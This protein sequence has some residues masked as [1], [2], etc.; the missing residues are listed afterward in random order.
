[1]RFAC[2]SK[3]LTASSGDDF[4]CA[5]VANICGI[6]KVLKISSMTAFVLPG[7]PGFVVYFSAIVVRIVYLP[8]GLCVSCAAIL[9]M[10]GHPPLIA[11]VHGGNVCHLLRMKLMA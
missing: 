5:T 8:F 3:F 2:R 11:P 1:M 4:P 9:R 10:V 7:W 6:M